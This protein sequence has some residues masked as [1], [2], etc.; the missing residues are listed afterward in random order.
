MLRQVVKIAADKSRVEVT[1]TCQCLRLRDCFC[2][3]VHACDRYS[4][5]GPAECVLTEMTL[6]MQQRLARD[7]THFGHIDIQQRTL[8]RLKPR[9]IIKFRFNM[10]PGPLVPKIIDSFSN[11]RSL[12]LSI[13]PNIDGDGRMRDRTDGDAIHPA[14]CDRQHII[15]R[16][17]AAGFQQRFFAD[18]DPAVPQRA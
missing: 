14:A 9:N 8:T 10:N 1:F 3:K 16:N 4:S 7:V 17:T 2:R 12:Y 6:K 15:Q 18:L 11:I 5:S 13:Q